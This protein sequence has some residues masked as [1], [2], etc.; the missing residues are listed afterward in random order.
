MEKIS[1]DKQTLQSDD[2]KSGRYDV[3]KTVGI[4][5]STSKQFERLY[6]GKDLLISSV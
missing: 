6:F 3:M 2:V 4:C 1:G 5:I